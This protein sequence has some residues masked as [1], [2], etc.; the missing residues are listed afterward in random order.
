MNGSVAVVIDDDPGVRALLL[1]VF[2]SAGFQ[3]VGAENGVEGVAT[4][5]EQ[6][7]LITTVSV[8]MPGID[9]FET[10]KP[11][12]LACAAVHGNPRGDAGCRIPRPR[13]PPASPEATSTSRRR[14]QTLCEPEVQR[15]TGENLRATATAGST[16]HP[17]PT[18]P[19][20]ETPT[21]APRWPSTQRSRS[22]RAASSTT[23][24]PGEEKVSRRYLLP[25][26][27]TRRTRR[28]RGRCRPRRG[29][30]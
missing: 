30:R 14:R 18:P 25:R 1:D 9:G 16:R 2:E 23:A 13:R 26:A 27:A 10:V 8:A 7:P 6:H 5:R 28:S 24:N 11:H 22:A 12:R 20:P 3:A 17:N 19:R 4:V 29:W 21:T 15:R